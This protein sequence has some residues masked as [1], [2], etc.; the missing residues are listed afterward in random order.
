ML[1]NSSK[2]HRSPESQIIDIRNNKISNDQIP[3]LKKDEPS[4]STL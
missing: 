1:D 2:E 4:F 3:S